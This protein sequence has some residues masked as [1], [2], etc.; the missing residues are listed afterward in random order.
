LKTQE[1]RLNEENLKS[2]L[3]ESNGKSESIL[4]SADKSDDDEEEEVKTL[5]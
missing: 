3:T 4:Q 2:G 1:S 5:S